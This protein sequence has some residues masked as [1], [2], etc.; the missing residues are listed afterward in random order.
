M[1]EQVLEMVT[2]VKPVLRKLPFEEFVAIACSPM[3]GEV[4]SAEVSRCDAVHT[5]C[6]PTP[7]CVA[8]VTLFT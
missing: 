7:R 3:P 1:C 6:V 8:L 5:Y 2:E 4:I